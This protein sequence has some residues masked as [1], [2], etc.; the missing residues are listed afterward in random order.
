MK[1]PQFAE[2]SDDASPVSQTKTGQRTGWGRQPLPAWVLWLLG[3][4]FAAFIAA[5]WPHRQSL[6]VYEKHLR[7]S[8]LDIQLAFEEL[9]G[10]MDEA[11]FRRQ[12]GDI[13]LSCTMDHALDG[14]M[15]HQWLRSANDVP[16]LVVTG[17]FRNGRL[18]FAF[19]HV[20]WWAHGRAREAMDARWG[21]SESGGGKDARGEPFR[22][23]R[24]PN[25]W[26][27]MNDKRYDH[28]L[29]WSVVVWDDR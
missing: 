3:L 15:C 2:P 14:R 21:P 22:R 27:Y 8:A 18:D 29:Q 4:G 23:W 17:A 25:G 9:D 28:P 11:A 12:L 7:G 24:L 19:L 26:L 5:V 10:G 6:H 13:Y 1:K 16:A 20:P